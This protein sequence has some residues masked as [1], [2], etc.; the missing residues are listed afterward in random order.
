MHKHT[1][2]SGIP[3]TARRQCQT[4]HVCK[5]PATLRDASAT[6]GWCGATGDHVPSDRPPHRRTFYQNNCAPLSGRT[7]NA[8]A[9]IYLPG[10]SA[11]LAQ[12]QRRLPPRHC[13]GQ[14]ARARRVPTCAGR[15]ARTY[16]KVCGPAPLHAFNA[17]KRAKMKCSAFDIACPGG[18]LQRRQRRPKQSGALDRRC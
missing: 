7:F 15:G 11:F 16:A 17:C 9:A 8:R 3:V 10:F 12:M 4:Q 2:K 18:G 14:S 13:A 6:L 5:R 1:I